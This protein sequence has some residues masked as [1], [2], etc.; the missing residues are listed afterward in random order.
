MTH[1]W[2]R[3]GGRGVKGRRE[4]GKAKVEDKGERAR[5]IRIGNAKGEGIGEGRKD[6]KKKG[7]GG[8]DNE[9]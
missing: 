8:K 9:K 7:G 5:Y 2:S 4:L 6:T 3:E 1:T